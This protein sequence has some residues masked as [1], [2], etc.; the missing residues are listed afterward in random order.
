MY[1]RPLCRGGQFFWNQN[2]KKQVSQNLAGPYPFR[3]F[4]Q[5]SRSPS[6]T[7]RGPDVRTSAVGQAAYSLTVSLCSAWRMTPEKLTPSRCQPFSSSFTRA[8][9]QATGAPPKLRGG[10]VHHPAQ[11]WHPPGCQNG[12]KGGI[13]SLPSMSRWPTCPNESTGL[14]LLEVKDPN[15]GQ[16]PG[17]P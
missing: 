4:P 6:R 15:M 12:Q 2:E 7:P 5:L 13:R 9:K 16:A 14:S 11:N 10:S 1:D 3:H 17:K 8:A